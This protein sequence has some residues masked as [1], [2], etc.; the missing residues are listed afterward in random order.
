MN[1][2][3][4]PIEDV[5]LGMERARH[6]LNRTVFGT[7]REDIERFAT[8][9]ITQALEILLGETIAPDP[10]LQVFGEDPAV[11]F[12]ETWVDAALN[13]TASPCMHWGAIFS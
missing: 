7:G 5:P 9:T 1:Y 6:L 10:P 4:D 3:I 12:G 2:S 13:G 8:L 11:P